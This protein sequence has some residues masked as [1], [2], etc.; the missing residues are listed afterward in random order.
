M[1]DAN[2]GEDGTQIP[3]VGHEPS[4][5]TPSLA[6]EGTSGIDIPIGEIEATS[7]FDAAQEIEYRY[8]TFESH[9]P[10]IPVL[11]PDTKA[12]LPPCPDL[13]KYDDPFT[14]SLRRKNL[15]TYLACSVNVTAAYS[16]GS[17]S[18]PAFVLTKKWGVSDVAYNVGITI[19]TLGFGVAPMVL[20]PFSEINGRRPVFIATG[21]LFVSRL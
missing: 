7:H 20:A 4:T 21:L 8:L 11:P 13:R 10:V 9:I 12:D 5:M 18:S 3:T 19:F 6:N 14:W 2:F 1:C 15:L 16:A 17:Y